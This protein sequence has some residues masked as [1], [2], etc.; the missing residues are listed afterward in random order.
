MLRRATAL[1]LCAVTALPPQTAFAATAVF[2]SPTAAAQSTTPMVM[3][4]NVP[5]GRVDDPYL[6]QFRATGGVPPYGY[7]MIGGTVP[8]GTAF[9][10]STGDISGTPPVSGTYSGIK[11]RA[12]DQNGATA[13]SAAYT[14]TI[15]GRPLSAS[16]NIPLSGSLGQP[17]YGSVSAKGGTKP[18]VF[19]IYSGSLPEGLSIDTATGEITGVP[20][21]RGT[22]T[23]S[24]RIVD[25][26]KPSANVS[27]TALQSISVDYAPLAVTCP[28]CAGVQTAV[29]NP[30]DS[31][32]VASGGQGPYAYYVQA[33]TLPPGISLDRSTGRLFGSPTK[34]G[35]YS[36][37]VV[38]AVDVDNRYV[39]TPAFQFAVQATVAVAGSP[40]PFAT[41]GEA[42]AANFQAI[43]GRDPYGWNLIGTLPPGLAFDTGSGAI[44]GTPTQVGAYG[45]LQ[46]RAVDA[47]A[48]AAV[49]NPFAIS[50]A[51]PVA[52]AGSTVDATVGQAYRVDFTATGGRSPYVFTL[53]SGSLPSGLTLGQSGALAG[54]PTTLGTYRDIVVR[55][56]D[57]D[58][59][60]AVRGPLSIAVL[61]PMAV[62]GTMPGSATLGEPYATSFA[63]TGGRAPYAWTV[64]G[65]LP[66]GISISATNGSISG[67]PTATGAY[68]GITVNARDADGRTAS[69]GPFS[70]GIADPLR[71]SVDRAP[72]R[73]S[74]VGEPV[75]ISTFKG[76][77]GTVP[78]A[79]SLQGELPAGLVYDP[80][81]HAIS[82][83]PTT[84]G[85]WSGIG[86]ALR[87]GEGRSTS[88]GPYAID[89][90]TPVQIAAHPSDVAVGDAVDSAATVSGGVGPY[91]C[92]LFAGSWPPGI[93]FES[94]GSCRIVGTATA[95]GT[96]S[97]AFAATDT[98]GRTGVT[99]PF[100]W[101]ILDPLTV[102]GTPPAVSTVGTA[103]VAQ[104]DA[105]G[106]S[107]PYAWSLAAG[108]L[109]AGLLLDAASGSISGSPTVA[110]LASGLQVKAT[111]AA[112]RT[113][114]STAFTLDVRNPLSV[115]GSPSANATV[116]QAYSA[117]FAAMGGRGPYAYALV[118]GPLP[119]GL[120]LSAAGI[121]SG[122]PT[123][124]ANAT[125]LRVRATDA[126][127]RTAST[128]SFRIAVSAGL[129]VSGSPAAQGTVGTAYAAA[130]TAAGG[131]PAYTWS[132]AAGTLPTGLVLDPV[133]GTI[134]GSP[135]IAGLASGLQV[136]ATDAAGRT[137]S[138]ATFAIDVREL[139]TISGTPSPVATIGVAYSAAFAAAGGRPGYV[140]R[141]AA[142]TLPA[143][144]TLSGAGRIAGTPTASGVAEGL[145]IGVVD[146]DGR[147]ALTQ[148]F[149]ISVSADLVASGNPPAFATVGQPYT[150]AFSAAGGTGPYAWTVSAGILPTGLT[151]D[152]ATGAIA[153][154]PVAIGAA[155]GIRLRVA[156]AEGRTAETAAFSIDVRDVLTISGTPSPDATLGQA[157]SSAFVALGDR[158]G[159]GFALVA[160]TLPVGISL[161]STG[162]LSGVPT[163]TGSFA[164][165][166]VKVTDADGRTALSSPF[167][168]AVAADVT[169]AGTPAAYGTIGQT[170]SAPF[171]ATGG[172][173]PYAWTLDSGTLPI[174]LSL[175]TSGAV[176]GTP[177]TAGTS[178]GIR[179]RAT[180][181]AG[182]SGLSQ[183]FSIA[184]AQP[185]AVAGSPAALAT[186][187]TAYT[188]SFSATGGRGPYVFDNGLGTLPAGLSISTA[189]VLAGVPT[190]AE[191]RTDLQVRVVDADGRAAYS[192]PFR[193]AVSDKLTIAGIPPV[194]MTAG[195]EYAFSFQAAGGSKPY[196]F[197]VSAGTLPPGLALSSAGTISGTATSAGSYPGIQV[198]V[199]DRDGR[200]A[201]SASFAILV[202]APLT[203]SGTAPE[204]ATIGQTYAA[205]FAGAGGHAPYLFA[206]AGSLPDG[207]SFDP[208]TGKLSGMPSVAGTFPGLTVSVRDADGRTAALPPF[209][210][211]VTGGLTVTGSPPTMV[212]QGEYYQGSLSAAGGTGPYTFVLASGDLPDGVSLGS[213]GT[214]GGWTSRVATH[215]FR[216]QA[217][218]ANGTKALS[219]QFDVQVLAPVRLVGSLP[220]NWDLGVYGQ[221]QFQATGGRGPYTF[222][223]DPGKPLPAGLS[224][225]LV[226][227]R[228][229]GTPTEK[230]EYYWRRIV[231]TDVDGRTGS[232]EWTMSVWEPMKA[233]I[234]AIPSATQGQPFTVD[235]HCTGPR[236]GCGFSARWVPSR[237]PPGLSIVNDPNDDFVGHITGTPTSSGLFTGIGIWV[238]DSNDRSVYVTDIDILVRAPVTVSANW[239]SFGVVGQPYV[240]TF[241]AAGGRSPLTFSLAA[242]TLPEG[243]TLDPNSGRISGTPIRAESQSGIRVRATDPDGRTGTSAAFA[244]TISLPLTISG[245]APATGSVGTPYSVQ[246][247]AA[248]GRQPYSYALLGSLPDGLRLAA[249]T[250]L[251]SGTPTTAVTATNI[252]VVATDSDGRKASTQPFSIAITG[253]LAIAGTP[254]PTGRVGSAY[255]A[256]F[257][258]S[259]GTG[260]YAIALA[261]GSL[262]AGLALSSSG[263]ITGAPTEAGTFSY[264]VAAT[265]AA[266]AR[267]TTPTF[268]LTVNSAVAPLAIGSVPNRFGTVGEAYESRYFGI[269]G[270][271]PYTYAISSGSL[272]DGLILADGGRI[273]GVPTTKGISRFR[274]AVTDAAGQTAETSDQSIDV[275]DPLVLLEQYKDVRV[276]VGDS[277][278]MDLGVTGGTGPYTVQLSDGADILPPGI[279]LDADN[280]RLY[281]TYTVANQ[282]YSSTT[283]QYSVVDAVGRTTTLATIWF[284]VGPAMIVDPPLNA[285]YVKGVEI[286]DWWYN[287]KPSSRPAGGQGPWSVEYSVVGADAK[288]PPG[289]V[290]ALGPGGDC[291][292]FCG[293][294][295]G[296]SY[297]GWP[298]HDPYPVNSPYGSF[299]WT[300]TET[301]TFGPIRITLRDSQ[302]H[303]AQAET[304]VVTVVDPFTYVEALPDATVGRPYSVDLRTLG[305]LAPFVYSKLSGVLPVGLV[306]DTATG[307]ISGIP[308]GAAGTYDRLQ[309]SVDWGN[310]FSGIQSPTYSIKVVDPDNRPAAPLAVAVVGSNPPARVIKGKDDGQSN[311]IDETINRSF[312]ATGGVPPYTFS[313]SPEIVGLPYICRPDAWWCSE[314]DAGN[315]YK[316]PAVAVD[317]NGNF[318][319]VRIGFDPWYGTVYKPVPAGQIGN[320]RIRV[321]DSTGA[322]ADTTPF[323]MDFQKPIGLSGSFPANLVVGDTVNVVAT[324]ADGWQPI[325]LTGSVLPPGLTASISGRGVTV[326]GKVTT[327]G[328]YAGSVVVRDDFPMDATWSFATTV[329]QSVAPLALQSPGNVTV[330]AGDYY[331]LA[332]TPSG[333]VAPYW[334]KILSGTLPPGATLDY[335]GLL[336]GTTDSV[337]TWSDIVLQVVDADGAVAV[338]DPVSITVQS[339]PTQPTEPESGDCKDNPYCLIRFTA[340]IPPFDG[341]IAPNVAVGSIIEAY[342]PYY[343]A[344]GVLGYPGNVYDENGNPVEG[345]PANRFGPNPGDLSILTY[346]FVN[347]PSWLTW[348][349]P[350]LTTSVDDDTSPWWG[351]YVY[352]YF[353]QRPLQAVPPPPGAPNDQTGY[354]PGPYE[355]GYDGHEDGSPPPQLP[356]LPPII[357]IGLQ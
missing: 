318:S 307:R 104:F 196:A 191:T 46:A 53:A 119:A 122:T 72:D 124:V 75:A 151:L 353:N 260:P 349:G 343:R 21:S 98:Q 24:V 332:W 187:G 285:L 65:S 345:S 317:Q 207:L 126:D 125:G 165:L 340:G 239:T 199:T 224:M 236:Y 278:D 225:D 14:V 218:D 200:T 161:S 110:G 235:I 181:S 43:G 9:N 58:G 160:G 210:I 82:G 1:L 241:S 83:T 138:S 329:R 214:I 284:Y 51:M 193:I 140:Y 273:L 354:V 45:G 253:P 171:V 85:S 219:R 163:A 64:G 336:E 325:A 309:F 154:S 292:W 130:F 111:D 282:S 342:S 288:M 134:T 74:T 35:T 116:G 22:R 89:V 177:T 152:P 128:D 262:P 5:Q 221:Y 30:Y 232:G 328:T 173:G 27:T 178:S 324:A 33:G 164:G 79:F 57:A 201:S 100:D 263:R 69:A 186:V 297:F 277:G 170:Y 267:A 266:G 249:S 192:A 156:D 313:L 301:G 135:T 326:T 166:Q 303:V 144:L 322:T 195:D 62:T 314:R 184:V 34:A 148:A 92:S 12:T 205:Q 36:N 60:S 246:F 254:S 7:E 222:S 87:D 257:A 341:P 23:F 203:I 206:I 357:G 293:I 149:S 167:S 54:T 238:H 348:S 188:A 162:A 286:M 194:S 204:T 350:A 316:V 255:T 179:V 123:S 276:I 8:T 169:V 76:A 215:S 49:S 159:Y 88:I 252:S 291:N 11:I 157:Y 146:A 68:G 141:V 308:T 77:G 344:P 208:A 279:N 347:A 243:V 198:S 248:G 158:S 306:L 139:L 339:K 211:S 97:L 320:I 312:Q 299:Y 295:E 137:A 272:P 304:P 133:A 15:S 2:R 150:A 290:E 346:E 240:S 231:A 117:T 127:G 355:H 121:L 26:T 280:L 143:G 352:G 227:G 331:A 229:S 155:T 330:T 153:G 315:D 81:K 105:V 91:T 66:P 310:W 338:A 13:T 180:D 17:Y 269:E 294:P 270:T 10:S 44:S 233:W 18:L 70:I 86:M 256:T 244:L 113:A 61:G 50:V 190:T 258:A 174:G 242:G 234:D 289:F 112:G 95:S 71:L 4:S 78:Y 131:S 182:R 19:T 271:A 6:A 333:G 216:V 99:Q 90:A 213:D 323:A 3:S 251:I 102:R 132:L 115:A 56:T 47:D 20:T 189:G 356:G 202:Y 300:P 25:A 296:T 264:A 220:Q 106:G 31:P 52:V 175:T 245:N 247:S 107:G 321:T 283:F 145:R 281:G 335:R 327:A 261:S 93:R 94:A 275:A 32:F 250:G 142:G 305:G 226:A 59:R 334:V 39:L 268:K 37:I 136:K 120:S 42:Y 274:V 209:G 129:L 80:A 55:A 230:G 176:A 73:Y 302:G 228:I 265:D 311:D 223:V 29:G 108:T 185:L 118:G 96:Y 67:S 259:G 168:I 109:P 237:L 28:P 40:S 103:Y 183:K 212:V 337:G 147:T 38:Q 84:P 351:Y 217:T 287:Y 16:T 319:R 101:R 48:R 114:L 172:A 298:G 63:A 197:S 41:V